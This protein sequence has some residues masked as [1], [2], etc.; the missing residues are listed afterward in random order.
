MFKCAKWT[1]FRTFRH[2]SSLWLT[3][4]WRISDNSIH[5]H[6]F[7]LEPHQPDRGYGFENDAYPLSQEEN[8]WGEW[9]GSLFR[10]LGL[11]PSLRQGAYLFPLYLACWDLRSLPTNKGIYSKGT[12]SEAHHSVLPLLGLF[13][14]KAHP[15]VSVLGVMETWGLTLS[16]HLDERFP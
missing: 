7:L 12:G 16:P 5:F 13:W 11:M 9:G 14:H 4:T 2:I 10:V 3:K 6:P 8:S 15:C 1:A